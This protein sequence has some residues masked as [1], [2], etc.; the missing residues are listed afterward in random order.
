VRRTPAIFAL[1]ALALPASALGA[2]AGMP[3]TA[4]QV[5]AAVMR[6]EHSRQLWTTIN[7]CNTRAHRDSIGIR[8]QMPSLGFPARLKMT[9]EVDYW[10]PVAKIFRPVPGS[11]SRAVAQLGTISDGLEQ[12]GH[13]FQF[14]PGAG[15]L[16]GTITFEWIRVGKVIG[17][18]SKRA[19]GGHRGVDHGDPPHHSAAT[20]KIG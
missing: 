19:T 17:Q 2:G 1:L 11:N 4:G 3:P 14:R 7:I 13:T 18:L 9:I 15:L 16:S 20:C 12:G 5:R 8:G 10:D 6:A